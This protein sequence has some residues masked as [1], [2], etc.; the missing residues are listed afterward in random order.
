MDIGRCI[1]I[2]KL[3]ISFGE[4]SGSSC[5]FW[6][7]VRFICFN[8]SH[9]VQIQIDFK[10]IGTYMFTEDTYV[11]KYIWFSSVFEKITSCWIL[12]G[13]ITHWVYDVHI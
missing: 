8:F 12:V 5:Y 1:C 10:Y 2:A 9:I 11:V 6:E 13:N 7:N 3:E 4:K